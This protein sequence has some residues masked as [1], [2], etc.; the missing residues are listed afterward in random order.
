MTVR[1]SPLTFS[2]MLAGDSSAN[3]R[4]SSARSA[5]TSALEKSAGRT[6]KPC[7]WKSVS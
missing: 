2:R 3:R 5:S 1:T 4:G 7:A 6:R